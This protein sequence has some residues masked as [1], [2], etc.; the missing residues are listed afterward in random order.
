[1]NNPTLPDVQAAAV[2]PGLGDPV[3]G[4]QA[5]FRLALTALSRPARPWPAGDLDLPLEAALPPLAAGL[6]LTLLDQETPVWLS[7][8]FAGAA[9]WLRFHAGCPIAEGPER[10]RFVLAASPAELPPL[11]ELAPGTDRYPDRSATVLL[12]GT[13]PDDASDPLLAEGP[14]IEG[15]LRFAGHGLPL[16]FLAQWADNRAAYPRGVDLFLLGRRALAGLPRTTDLRPWP[17]EGGPA[18]M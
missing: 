11:S 15:R 3:H 7:P 12:A 5:L 4:A 16:A 1:M 2:A 6:A 14:G 17:K 9:G 10:A 18:C 8:S 13:L